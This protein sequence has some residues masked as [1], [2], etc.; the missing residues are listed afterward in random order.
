MTHYQNTQSGFLS[1]LFLGMSYQHS[2]WQLLSTSALHFLLVK[3]VY[4]LLTTSNTN[5][6]MILG[7][8][9]KIGI[10]NTVMT[11][12]INVKVHLTVS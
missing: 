10:T 5:P 11:K 6:V 2:L 1:H 9:T 8:H 7:Y 3:D 12:Y 4:G